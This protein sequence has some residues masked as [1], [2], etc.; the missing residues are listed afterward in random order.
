MS[1]KFKRVVLDGQ[2]PLVF[3]E[4]PVVTGDGKKAFKTLTAA[5]R[6]AEVAR[7]EVKAELEAARELAEAYR[8]AGKE[9]LAEA[10]EL[11]EAYRAAAEALLEDALGRLQRVERFAHERAAMVRRW[12]WVDLVVF[13]VGSGV[14]AVGCALGWW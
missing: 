12:V 14:L 6:A 3:E 11:A 9:L 7:D 5:V 4:K 10:R 1:R 13:G 8:A 2:A